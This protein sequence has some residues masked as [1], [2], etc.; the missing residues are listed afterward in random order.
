MERGIGE[1]VQK[2]LEIDSVFF[3]DELS[4]EVD[5]LSTES[6]QTCNT[7]SC[8]MLPD[9]SDQI[10]AYVRGRTQGS[11]LRKWAVFA[12][13]SYNPISARQRLSLWRVIYQV[14]SEVSVSRVASQSATWVR[15]RSWSFWRMW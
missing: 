14:V 7:K 1:V 4:T 10:I 12:V 8:S 2:T 5:A 9:F 15:D 3:R 6:E 13:I 11:P